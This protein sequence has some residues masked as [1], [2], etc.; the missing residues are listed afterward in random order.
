[1]AFTCPVSV[2]RRSWDGQGKPGLSQVVPRFIQGRHSDAGFRGQEIK[3]TPEFRPDLPERLQRASS[4]LRIGIPV[5]ISDGSSGIL[6]LAVETA[7]DRRLTAAAGCEGAVL[8]VTA[9]RAATLKARIYDGDISR[10]RM[11]ADADPD[12]LRSLADP[13]TD[14]IHPLKGPLESERSGAAGPCRRA[15]ALARAA[16]LLPAIVAVPVEDAGKTADANGLVLLGPEI[17]QDVPSLPLRAEGVVSARLP[18]PASERSR[19][20][21]YRTEGANDEHCAI[22]VGVPPRDAPVLVRMHSA[23]FT[24]DVLGSLKCDCGPQLQAALDMISGE[25]SGILLY[26]NQEGRGIG[27]TN[28]VRAYSLQDQGFD[29][30]EANH[31]LGFE[32]DERDFRVGAEMLR[33]L[34]FSRVRLMTNNPA[35]LRMLEQQGI[36]VVERVPL[37]AGRTRHNEDYLSV[38]AAKSGHIL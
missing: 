6:A 2:V 19:I 14:L 4:D 31:R 27:L 38:K 20:H 33:K 22:E 28:K 18:L 25:G 26:L 12:R 34:G 37:V 3:V 21:V 9:R 29:T 32:D 30:V 10:I 36:G 13:S 35:K 11:P 17:R 24:G 16:R 7:S 5:V 8:V 23:C 15:I 1:M